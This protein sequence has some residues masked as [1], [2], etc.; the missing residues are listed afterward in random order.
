VTVYD[1]SRLS[2]LLVEDNQYIRHT[3]ED[4]LRHFEFGKIITAQHGQ[5]AI[6][7]LS[8]S[9]IAGAPGLGIDIVLADLIMSPI[10]GLLLTRWIRNSKDS[11]NRFMPVVLLSGAAD[12]EYVTAARDLGASEFLAKPFSAENVYKRLL[13]VIDYPRQII[14]THTY[15]GPDRRRRHGSY[16][17]QADRRKNTDKDITIVYS[18]KKT[19]KPAKASDVWCFRLPNALKGKAG[20]MGSK[21]GGEMPMALLEQAEEKLERKK[22]DFADWALKYLS[23]LSN[24]CA[25]ALIKPGRRAAHFEKIHLLAHELRG[26]GGTFG[27]PLITRVAKMLYDIT[28]EHCREDDS[29][30]E[31]VKAHIDTMRVVIRERISGDGGAIGKELLAGI[32]EAI[33]KNS[34]VG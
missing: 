23:E 34:K 22:L 17:A 8:T 24:L 21:G 32:Q 12:D 26:Q 16:D 25:D 9:A 6:E 2:I 15:F 18:G 19:T 28:H 3:L 30:V 11:P 1:F 10:N 5:E 4:L 13:E 33:E 7:I 14:A 31:I 27:Y 29:A 20:G